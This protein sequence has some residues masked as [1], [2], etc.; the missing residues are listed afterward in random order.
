[1]RGEKSRM[2]RI[3]DMID[4][5]ERPDRGKRMHHGIIS[6]ARKDVSP[7]LHVYN[8]WCFVEFNNHILSR[9]Y[10][11][12]SLS[13]CAAV[14]WQFS[15]LVLWTSIALGPWALDLGLSCCGAG[16]WT[17]QEMRGHWSW[18]SDTTWIHTQGFSPECLNIMSFSE[19]MLASIKCT[20]LLECIRALPD[21]CWPGSSCLDVFFLAW[22]VWI[23]LGLA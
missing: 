9:C 21:V 2:N 20:S 13:H 3:K 17:R 1:M 11:S 15:G 12:T 22:W 23:C 7:P 5:E 14:L 10:Q 4:S 16:R 18:K 6:N 8:I 19:R